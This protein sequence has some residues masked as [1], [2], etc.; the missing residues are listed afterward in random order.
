MGQELVVSGEQCNDTVEVLGV[1]ALVFAAACFRRM[2]S[3]WCVREDRVRYTRLHPTQPSS[4][5]ISRRVELPCM[6]GVMGGVL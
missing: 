4:S 5:R 6:S 3:A 2:A 1:N